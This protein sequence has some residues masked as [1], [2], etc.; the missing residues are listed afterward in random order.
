MDAPIFGPDWTSHHFNDWSHWL[1]AFAGKPVHGLE[2]GSFEGR[3]ARWFMEH[4]CTDSQSSL[5]CID[6][7]DYADELALVPG[8]A[9]H[10]IEQF[11]WSEVNRRFL[12][13]LRPWIA[14]RRLRFLQTNSRDAFS[15]LPPEPRYDFA[16][17][18]GSH[19][20]ACVLEDAVLVWPR[21][22]Q[23]AVLIFDDYRWAVNKPPPAGV[24]EEVM[25]PQVAIDAWLRVHA[26]QYT[27]L[28]HSNDQVKVRKR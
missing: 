17:I 25:R 10:I 13:N 14:D 18:D 9:T 21:L 6:P 8:G 3:S 23:G 27:D 26:G 7:H 28:V 11:D 2:I 4:I 22:K 20:A 24:P 19:F 5:T 1:A 12:H 16:Y 15:V